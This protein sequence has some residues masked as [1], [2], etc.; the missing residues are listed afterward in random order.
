MGVHGVMEQIVRFSQRLVGTTGFEYAVL[1]VVI[2][3]SVLLGMTTS[4]ALVLEYGDLMSIGNQVALGV[5]IVEALFKMVALAPR[6]DRYFRDGW[7][8]FDF[9][10]I[11]FALIPV[12]G[13]FALIFRL[14][15]ILR[16]VSM[17]EGLRV[18]V[19]TLLR[20]ITSVV[21][22]LLLMVIIVYIYAI[23]GS[24]IFQDHDPEHWHNIG[25]SAMT[26]FSMIT[27]EGW[28]EIMETAMELHPLAWTYFVSFIIFS[29]F[30][31]INMFIAVIINNWDRAHTGERD[32]S[33]G[34]KDILRDIEAAQE[35]LLRLEKRLDL[36]D[37]ESSMREVDD[38]RAS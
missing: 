12:T 7:N 30:V 24:L 5:F 28:V 19:T 32:S 13:E 29:S 37:K 26:L 2:V 10:V 16:L 35:A 20:S 34:R 18:I 33:A 1:A 23:L 38:G 14:L 9:S 22:I 6:A 4:Q 27:L 11:V 36:H 25:V 17:V 8:I 21:N 31:V 15:R 3:N